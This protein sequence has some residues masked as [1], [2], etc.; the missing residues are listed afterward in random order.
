MR[1][2]VLLAALLL[3]LVPLSARADD[4]PLNPRLPHTECQ[5]LTRQIAHFADVADLARERGNEP[6]ENATLDHI[7]RLS[8]RRY[9]MCPE[10][11]GMS[12]GEQLRQLLKL[13]AKIALKLY[14]MGLI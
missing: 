8:E 4:P 10:Y 14:T 1:R 12:Y 6:W 9:E 2:L 5:R 13:A 3:A 11:H 7:A